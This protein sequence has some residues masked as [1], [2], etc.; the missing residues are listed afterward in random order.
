[1]APRRSA[2]RSARLIVKRLVDLF[3][4]LATLVL[5]SPLLLTVA[6]AIK[7]TSPGPVLFRQTRVGLGGR[8][9]TIFKFRSMFVDQADPG[10]A[11]QA[12]SGDERVTPIGRFMRKSSIDELPQLVNILAGEMSLVGPRPYPL[13]MPAG[14]RP[15]RTIVPYF[16][17]REL[18]KPG[19]SGWAQANGYRGPTNLEESAR[20][21]LLHDVAY[22]QNFTLLLD[23]RVIVM[24]LWREFCGGTGV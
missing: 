16:G 6:I 2:A 14:D 7:C 17:F 9:F 4:S 3:L 18:M 10:G 5:L 24:T 1:V 15:Y 12:V 23:L 13:D 19:L 22:V 21:R 8:H 20:A 11:V